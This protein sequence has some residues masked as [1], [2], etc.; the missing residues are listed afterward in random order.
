MNKQDNDYERNR[1]LFNVLIK[2]FQFIS[3]I[4]RRDIR[5]QNYVSH[6]IELVRF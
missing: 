3:V 1:E 5:N 6:A 4:L 2:M